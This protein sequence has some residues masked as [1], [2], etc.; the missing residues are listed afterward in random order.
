MGL[1]GGSEISVFATA[2]VHSMTGGRIVMYLSSNENP[3]NSPLEKTITIL[4]YYSASDIF[5]FA[6]TTAGMI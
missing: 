4:T 1:W 2:N 5:M 3:I 6:G